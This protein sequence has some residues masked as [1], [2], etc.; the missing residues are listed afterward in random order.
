MGRLRLECPHCGTHSEFVS[1]VAAPADQKTKRT[2]AKR[3]G[4]QELAGNP[5]V[6]GFLEGVS[7]S[8]QQAWLQAYPAAFIKAEIT[9]A[10]LWLRANPHRPKSRPGAFM[11]N[12]LGRAAERQGAAFPP[13]MPAPGIVL[14]GATEED[15]P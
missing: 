3:G 7:H 2:A 5:V 11:T 8:V 4:V 9:K 10:A 12:W 15:E 14:A 13:G 1:A 6:D